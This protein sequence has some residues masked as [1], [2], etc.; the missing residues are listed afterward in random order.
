M[1]KLEGE[2]RPTY[3][4]SYPRPMRLVRLGLSSLLAG[5]ALANWLL[6]WLR[7]LRP[8]LAAAGSAIDPLEVLAAQPLRPLI[9]A[10]V[11]LPLVAAA[12]GLVYAFLPD[13]SLADEGL[14]M[15]TLL[16][17]RVVPWQ[18]ITAVRIT[19]FAESRRRLVLVQG[20]WARGAV[21]PRL[22][23]VCLGGGFEPGVL[24]TSAIRDFGP[25]MLRLYREVKKSAPEAVI[26]DQFL[27]PSALVVL[28]PQPTLS[29]LVK[30]ACSGGWPLAVS[31]Q[32]MGAVA[33]GLVVAQLL[34][35]LLFGATWWKPLAIVGL[36]A[37][38]WGIGALYLYALTEVWA[39]RVEFREAAL[40]YPLPQIPRALLSIGMA[41]FIC[42]GAPFLAAMLGLAGVVWAVILTAFLVQQMYQ[43][44][45]ILPAL[46]G[47]AL[48]ALYQFIVLAIVF[49]G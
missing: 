34:M 10:H 15:R 38:E 26:D 36:V 43:Q 33:G 42:A 35:M 13:L 39:V 40:L 16:G 47:G 11:S 27:S 17:W 22:I 25:L 23:S 45:S 21:W 4:L 12:L 2:E 5:A 49:S 3:V 28:E 44:E 1:S 6:A 8:V 9:A 37:L 31:A 30:Q 7:F 48:Q 18:T 24:L 41:M 14:A 46:A 19:A 29:M 20:R 32:I